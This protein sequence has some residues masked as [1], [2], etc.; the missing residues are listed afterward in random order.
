MGRRQRTQPRTLLEEVR[1]GDHFL[2]KLVELRGEGVVY[3]VSH[4]SMG[5]AATTRSVEDR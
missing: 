3:V 4:G 1:G 2:Q 5:A